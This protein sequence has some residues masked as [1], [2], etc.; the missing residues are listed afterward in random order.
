M[1]G[2]N[3]TATKNFIKKTT[4]KMKEM[5][6][7]QKRICIQKEEKTACLRHCIMYILN[8][9]IQAGSEHTYTLGELY[10][11]KNASFSTQAYH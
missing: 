6:S 11:H 3:S 9:C 10:K 8:C 4:Q 5:K 2:M 7:K 1:N